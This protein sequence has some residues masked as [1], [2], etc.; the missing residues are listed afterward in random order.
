[1]EK[2]YTIGDIHGQLEKLENL[3]AKLNLG[4]NDTLIFLGDYVDRGPDSVC[5]KKCC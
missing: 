4:K 1:M 3:I 5:P 2:I